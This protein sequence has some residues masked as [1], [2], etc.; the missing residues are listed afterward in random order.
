MFPLLNVYIN[1]PCYLANNQKL[2]FSFISQPLGNSEHIL[3]SDSSGRRIQRFCSALIPEI[4]GVIKGKKQA[5]S[6]TGQ[7]KAKLNRKLKTCCKER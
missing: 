1:K 7:G 3:K 4:K 2:P 5:L 6:V